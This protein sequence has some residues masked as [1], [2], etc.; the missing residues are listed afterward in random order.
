MKKL[1]VWD[2]V[3]II[4]GKHKGKISSI[5]SFVGADSVMI[6]WVNEVKRAKK[7]EWF[8]TKTLP[9]HISNVMYYVEKTTKAS[10][11]TIKTD[12]KGKKFR[13]AQKTGAAI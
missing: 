8:I 1:R 2:P 7:G 9:V 4:A 6:K 10:R 11:I 12:A 3:I 5:Q 13:V